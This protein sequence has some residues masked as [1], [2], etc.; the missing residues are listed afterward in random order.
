MAASLVVWVL[1]AL[2][3]LAL[4]TQ[5]W[6][7]A[8]LD[9]RGVRV[10]ELPWRWW[11]TGYPST[12]LRIKGTWRQVADRT[13]LTVSTRPDHRIIGRDLVV[14]GRS[15][16]QRAPRLSWPVPTRTG[17]RL[18]VVLHPGQTPGPYLAAARA[19]E[20]AWRVHAVRVTTP[21]RG[22]VVIRV[23]AVDP[24]TGKAPVRGLAP[25]AGVLVAHVGRTE[26]G[27]P[28]VID[29][30]RVPHWLITGAT[31][32]GKSTLLGA[33]VRALTPQPVT[34]L[35]VDLKGGVELGVFG[36]RF[37]ALATTRAQTIG[38]L[39]GVLDEIQRRTGLCRSARCRS[40]WELPDEDRPGPV[41]VLVD[42]LAEL[43]LTDGS[44]E[45][46]DEAERCGSLLL[47][48]AQLGAALG[49][50]L[51][52]AGQRVGSDLGPRVTALRSQLGGRVAHRAHDE[53]SAQ[54]TVGDLHA[55]AVAVIQSIGEDERG[56]AVV[57]T[58][59]GW[60]RAR[61]A[62]LTPEEIDGIAAVTPPPHALRLKSDQAQ[63]PKEG[64]KE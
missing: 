58:G 2:L 9:R 14:Q 28:W 57:T 1:S 25:A 29:L 44:R 54:M 31:R 32:S 45:G 49:V 52:V 4:L 36:G 17:L 55:D 27:E 42:E 34:L 20:H 47:R 56:V 51:I 22:V 5:G 24:L 7:S 39:G 48:V 60:M 43:Y 59:G 63:S 11:L 62:P 8:A 40:V 3:V 46:R 30:R 21:R 61:S 35:G 33:L 50:H 37:S 38:L 18:H 12:A 19:M 26:E 13:G 53:A 41:V 10:S 15:L 16:R 23:T 6:W 64:E